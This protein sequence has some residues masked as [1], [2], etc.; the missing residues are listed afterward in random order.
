MGMRSRMVGWR[1]VTVVRV[2]YWRLV[3]RPQDGVFVPAV[4]YR[5]FHN[6][7]SCPI[8]STC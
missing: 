4:D 3:R 1:G 2:G 5:H 7:N 8:L 6:L